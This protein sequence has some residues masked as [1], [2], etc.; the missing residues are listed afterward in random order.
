MRPQKRCAKAGCRTL[1]DY[2]KRY[3]DEHRND[4]HKQYNKHRRQYD[5]EYVSFYSS[6]DWRKTRYQAMLK[7][8]FQCVRCDDDS[9]VTT[10]V[11]VHHIQTVKDRPD[12][13]LDMDNLM[14]LCNECHNKI[15]SEMDR[16]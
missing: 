12:L 6:S 3:C 15:H 1:I 9:I 16:E 5:R 7:T 11:M 8:G 2:D 14:P 13:K 4:N 10:A